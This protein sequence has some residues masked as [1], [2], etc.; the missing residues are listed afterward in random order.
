MVSSA[1]K[2]NSKL[3]MM[4]SLEVERDVLLISVL[5]GVVATRFWYYYK[6][7]QDISHPKKL[8]WG[9]ILYF[10]YKRLDSNRVKSKY[11]LTQV[12][13]ES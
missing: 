3:P 8:I 1:K 4:S 7:L 12:Y 2:H 10:I 5:E 11:K 6:V 9:C 13:S